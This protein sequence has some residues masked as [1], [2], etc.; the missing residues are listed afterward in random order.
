MA[1]FCLSDVFSLSMELIQSCMTPVQFM[2]GHLDS[3]ETPLK[4]MFEVESTESSLSL[5]PSLCMFISRV[6]LVLCPDD[7]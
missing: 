7:A 1:F 2:Q 6:R 5:I 4:C 3:A